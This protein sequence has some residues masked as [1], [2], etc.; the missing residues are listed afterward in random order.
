MGGAEGKRQPDFRLNRTYGRRV[1]PAWRGR[2]RQSRSVQGAQF[3]GGAADVEEVVA[4]GSAQSVG[5]G[6][7]VDSYAGAEP[8]L[9]RT[10][11]EEI[12]GG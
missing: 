1:P 6:S 7:A 9:G 12:A 3:F 4:G 8:V 11:L 2:A 5:G 10:G